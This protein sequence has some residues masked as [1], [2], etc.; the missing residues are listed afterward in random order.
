MKLFGLLLVAL[1]LISTPF[2]DSAYSQV[3]N[4]Q[5]TKGLALSPLREE[6][7]I[8][9]GTTQKKTLS[10]TNSSD[11]PMNIQLSAE[12]FSVVNHEYRYSFDEDDAVAR[13]VR[14]GETE[15]QLQPQERRSIAYEVAV[16]IGTEPGGAYISI[17]ATND[18]DQ[19]PSAITLRQ[20]IGLLLY[21]TVEGE[22]TRSGSLLS[23]TAPW[24]VGSEAQWS[25]TLQN[26]GSA[27]FRS[28]H[29]VVV[30]DVFGGEVARA[31][32]EAL[33][34]PGTVRRVTEPLPVLAW[35]GIYRLDYSIGLGDQPAYTDSRLIVVAPLWIWLLSAIVVLGIILRATL[36]STQ[37]SQK[38]NNK[39]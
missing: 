10:L 37:T 27:H 13:W 18:T 5:S 33:V 2:N 6:I 28:R 1:F 38:R 24:I 39:G 29:E 34:L 9:P 35:P 30:H 36:R 7:A 23:L 3:V 19:E 4:D 31:T 17:F 15:L 22:V 32:G 11:Q 12:V 26:T 14:F 21:I 8:T 20:R 25:A 16:P